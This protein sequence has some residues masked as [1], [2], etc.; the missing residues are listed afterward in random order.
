MPSR[1]KVYIIH[2]HRI[3]VESLR[4]ALGQEADIEVVAAQTDTMLV[5][6]RV[7]QTGAD[8]VIV[9]ASIGTSSLLALCRAIRG[10]A[11]MIVLTHEQDD[12]L[13]ACIAGGAAG[14]LVGPHALSDLVSVIRRAHAGWAVLTIDQLAGLIRQARAG[15]TDPRAVQLWA[16]LSPRERDVLTVLATGASVAETA[17]KLLISSN[18]VQSHLKNAIRKLNTRT[19]LGAIIL[20]LRAGITTDASVL[21][22]EALQGDVPFSV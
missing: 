20:A 10:V 7:G 1:I 22:D 5:E 13:A 12:L 16:R 8:V 14:G 4:V 11:R 9:D 19:R 15:V 21:A 3:A 17:D 6:E 18:T 2:T